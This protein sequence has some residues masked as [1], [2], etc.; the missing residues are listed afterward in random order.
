MSETSS[1]KYKIL[2]PMSGSFAEAVSAIRKEIG[3]KTIHM[4]RIID[5]EFIEPE[6]CFPVAVPVPQI[7]MIVPVGIVSMAKQG[8]PTVEGRRPLTADQVAPTVGHPAYV[9]AL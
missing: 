8:F 1:T 7:E 4:D 5:S 6:N 2:S 3:A 9:P